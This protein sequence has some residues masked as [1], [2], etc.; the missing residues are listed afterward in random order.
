MIFS[1][2]SDNENLFHR[3]VSENNLVEVGLY[4]VMFGTRVR[5][6]FVGSQCCNLDWCGGADPNNIQALYSFAIGILEKRPESKRCFDGIPSIS[7]IK[8][9]VKDFH[10]LKTLYE[11]CPDV[12]KI[13]IYNE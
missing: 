10:F 2:T 1:L 8:P 6:G 7:Q 9:F 11:L 4:K 13:E 3:R 12:K 5:A